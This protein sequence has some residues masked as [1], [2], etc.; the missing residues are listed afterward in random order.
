VFH[1]SAGRDRTGIVAALV[2]SLLGV[3]DKVIVDDYAMSKEAMETMVAWLRAEYADTADELERFTPAMLAVMP[4][5]MEGLLALVRHTYGSAEGY[6]DFLDM[7]GAV[8]Y[9]RSA[10]LE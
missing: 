10:L 2:L 1:C 3:P 7:S 6:A 8:K 5:A 4:E 9:L